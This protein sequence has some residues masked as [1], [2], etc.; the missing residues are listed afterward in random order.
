[1]SVL[2]IRKYGDDVLRRR[3]EPVTGFDES[4]QKLIDDMVD[5]M[6]AAP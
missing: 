6:H 5:T 4:L 1:M 3:T 2:P